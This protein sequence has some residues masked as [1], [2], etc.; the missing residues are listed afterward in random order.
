MKK[1][2]RKKY[3]SELRLKIVKEFRY[4]TSEFLAKK[5]NI[6][7]STIKS[8]IYNYRFG[9]LNQKPGP[10]KDSKDI[11]YKE[12]YEILKKYISFQNRRSRRKK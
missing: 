5:Y 1:S 8:W 2:F 3:S 7:R 4:Y 9:K 6:N 12:K 10:K 11:N